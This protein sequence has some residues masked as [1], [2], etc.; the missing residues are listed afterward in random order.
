M[1]LHHSTAR[2]VQLFELVMFILQISRFCHENGFFAK[3]PIY[4]RFISQKTAS[5][6][7][8]CFVSH[9]PKQISPA[10]RVTISRARSSISGCRVAIASVAQSSGSRQITW[11]FALL[12]CPRRS[13]WLVSLVSSACRSTSSIKAGHLLSYSSL[14]PLLVALIYGFRFPRASCRGATAAVATSAG[15]PP[16]QPRCGAVELTAVSIVTPIPA[17]Q[18]SS[19]A[20]RC[21]S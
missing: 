16:N 15:C 7:S 9:R 12:Q 1:F 20:V 18:S 17:A 4:N 19:S 8:P 21:W 2:I 10:R 5:Y 3:L 6:S 13:S 11:R 14:A